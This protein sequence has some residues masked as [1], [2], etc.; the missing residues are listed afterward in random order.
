M[1]NGGMS[2]SQRGRREKINLENALHGHIMRVLYKS[3]N[4]STIFL[5]NFVKSC[6]FY[7]HFYFFRKIFLL[8]ILAKISNFLLIFGQ[9]YAH[10]FKFSQFWSNYRN[11][12]NL[13]IFGKIFAIFCLNLYE[14]FNFLFMFFY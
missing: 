14:N 4:F 11:F 10:N 3:S 1:S 2:P 12:P 5:L 6:Q 7:A 13:A 8:G 9:F